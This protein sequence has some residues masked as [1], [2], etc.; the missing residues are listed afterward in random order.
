MD[1]AERKE[2]QNT[3]KWQMLLIQLPLTNL[4][5]KK[6]SQNWSTLVCIQK[7]TMKNIKTMWRGRERERERERAR[8][9]T[10]HTESGREEE[11]DRQTDRQRQ[12]S[13][14][15]WAIFNDRSRQI[16][17]STAAGTLS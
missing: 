16:T 2:K 7:N 14:P 12:E 6:H 4:H 3:D 15:P 10:I 5:E 1:T 17:R 11:T 8:E 13:E 9:R